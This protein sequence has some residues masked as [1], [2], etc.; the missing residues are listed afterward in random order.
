LLPR[1]DKKAS[2]ARRSE[3][4]PVSKMLA[5]AFPVLLI[6]LGIIVF[7]FEEGWSLLTSVYVLVQIITTVG[8]GDVTAKRTSTKV[9][10][11]F[12][13]MLLLLV[14]AYYVNLLI[15]RFLDRY[16]ASLKKFLANREGEESKG[17]E[18]LNEAVSGSV[19]F[20][21]VMLVGIVFFRCADNHAKS[22]GDAFYMSSITMTTVGFGDEVPLTNYGMVFCIVWM[23]VGVAATANFVGAWSSYFFHEE[24]HDFFNITDQLQGVS[25]EQFESMDIL[26]TGTLSRGEFLAF[27]IVKYFGVDQEVIDGIF[28]EFETIDKEGTNRV[29]YAMFLER[30]KE[31][32]MKR[33]VQADAAAR[34]LSWQG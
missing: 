33:R 21:V 3:V 34:T 2:G 9:F 32:A 4:V 26:G 7:R 15:G 22:W 20:V 19:G 30:Q 23:L 13:V 6:V 14:V 10:M 29:T 31:L 17:L 25:E 12:Y 27:S 18:H 28:K 11:G 1:R 8:Y 5:V 16:N 24:S